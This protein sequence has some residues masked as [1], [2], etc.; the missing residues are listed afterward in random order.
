MKFLILGDLHG[1]IPKIYFKDFDAI[2]T[3]GDFCDGSK[4]R[5][6]IF[7][8]WDS[9]KYWHEI[10]GKKK[11]KQLIKQD[12][13]SGRKTRIGRPATDE[14]TAL[15]TDGRQGKSSRGSRWTHK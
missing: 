4:I 3:P 9:G 11:A 5:K 13:K 12:L 15:R 6:I 10:V 8:K 1:H 14:E 7:N 2:I